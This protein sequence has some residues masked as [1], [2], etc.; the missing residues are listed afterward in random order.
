MED[1]IN[2]VSPQIWFNNGRIDSHYG[3]TTPQYGIHVQTGELTIGMTQLRNH[4]SGVVR[5]EDG[6]TCHW[7][8]GN[9][10]DVGA[11]DPSYHANAIVTQNLFT[12]IDF[13]DHTL[14]AIGEAQVRILTSRNVGESI[15]IE[16]QIDN[17]ATA[18]NFRS[19]NGSGTLSSRLYIGAGTRPEAFFLGAQVRH[20]SFTDANRGNASDFGA[21]TEIWNTDDNAPNFSDGANWRDAAGGIT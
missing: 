8:M 6:A 18:M 5:V 15:L 4:I 1:S 21:G 7:G 17:S 13:E 3:A 20:N 9:V 14:S 12:D 19:K 2:G 10:L 11:A 16:T